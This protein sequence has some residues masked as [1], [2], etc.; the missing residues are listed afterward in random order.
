MLNSHCFGILTPYFSYAVVSVIRKWFGAAFGISRISWTVLSIE[1]SST[2]T[3]VMSSNIR[4]TS[5]NPRVT[6]SNPQ[7]RGLK[8]LVGRL[9]ARVGR[10]KARVKVY[11]PQYIA[12]LATSGSIRETTK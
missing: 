1:T 11:E 3:Q 12:Y 5:S 9:K 7:V 4:V 2:K 8:A 10:L 6:S